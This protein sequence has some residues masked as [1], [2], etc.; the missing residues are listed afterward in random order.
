M[1]GV[2]AVE[3]DLERKVVVV[4]GDALADDEIRAAIDEAGYD[5][6]RPGGVT[7]G[8]PRE[9]RRSSARAWRSS[10]APLRSPAPRT[11]ARARRAPQ[12]TTRCTCS[13]RSPDGTERARV[14]RRRLHARHRRARCCRSARSAVLPLPHPRPRGPPGDELRPRRRRPPAPDRRPPRPDRLS[15]LASAL[16]RATGPGACPSHWRRPAPTA[17]T[18]TSRSTAR[19]PCSAPTSSPPGRSSRRPRRLPRCTR[20]PT[21]T[22]SS[23]RTARCAPAR[24]ASSRFRVRRGGQPVTRFDE[25]VGR[26][27]HLVALHEG[28]LAYTHVHPVAGAPAGEIGFDAELAAAGQYRLFLQF[29]TG[30]VVHTVAVRSSRWRDER[31]S[32]GSTCRSRG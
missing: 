22:T 12:P 3:V 19:R 1:A 26:R 30:G 13:R 20:A 17:P 31:S 29:K 11:G 24:R 27:G 14:E 9:A 18:P 21:A 15:A 8:A 4:R 23:S 7:L 28:D 16:R 10:A 25:Y 2:D 6:E 5:V 32:S